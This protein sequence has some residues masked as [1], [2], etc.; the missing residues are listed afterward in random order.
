M[1]SMEDLELLRAAIAVALADGDLRR[2]EMGVIKGLA[3]R[4]GVGRVSFDA[5][6]GTA[7]SDPS[8]ADSIII[9]SPEKARLAVEVLVAEAGLDGEISPQERAVIQR[10]ARQ[11][12]IT[13]QELAELYVAGAARADALRKHHAN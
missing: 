3:V 2:S 9:S 8:F 5:M 7:E 1:A 4:T 11:L 6:L 10:I 12:R 13:D